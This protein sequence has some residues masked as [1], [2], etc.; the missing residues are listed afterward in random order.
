M[1]SSFTET[2]RHL[3]LI[4]LTFLSLMLAIAFYITINKKV[5]ILVFLL[6]FSASLVG[7]TIP[8]VGHIA[9]VIR[10][11]VIFLLLFLG[12]IGRRLKITFGY[13]LFWGYAFL[14]FIF[15]LFAIN[16]NY[17]LQRSV[18]LIGVGFIMP[19][20]FN[21][22][23]LKSIHLSMEGVAVAGSTFNFLNFV[24]LPSNL[25]TVSRFSGFAKS[26]PSFALFIGALLPFTLWGLW[27]SKGLVKVVCWFG[28]VSGFITLIFSGQRTGTLAGIVSLPPLLLLM[29][30]RKSNLR[31]LILM[32]FILLISLLIISISNE[33]RNEFLLERYSLQSGLTGRVALWQKAFSE[34]GKNPIIGRGTGAAEMIISSSFHNAYL[35]VWYNTGVFGLILFLSSQLLFLCQSLYLSIKSTDTEIKAI[36]MLAFG[37]MIGFVISCI[38]ES[39]GASASS[40]NILLYLFLGFLVTS[41]SWDY[42]PAMITRQYSYNS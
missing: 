42:Y 17:Q 4:D 24:L 15:L 11:V 40:V 35:E 32:I 2:I 23:D 39:I 25:G 19:L 29:Q 30:N 34:I 41:N 13:L 3:E 14:G 6:I 37:F 8:V 7:S 38:F 1:E 9:P 22:I 16:F 36:S 5:H 28:F 20:I 27:K 21:N 33:S 18:L 12:L 10:W 26:A 31:L